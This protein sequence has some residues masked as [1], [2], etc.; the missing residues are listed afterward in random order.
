MKKIG[1]VIVLMLMTGCV[2]GGY[3]Q[4]GYIPVTEVKDVHIT[5]A[6]QSRPKVRSVAAIKPHYEEPIDEE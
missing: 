5:R 6:E 3:I 1:L 2:R 4:L